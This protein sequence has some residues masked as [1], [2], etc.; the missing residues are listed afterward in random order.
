MKIR[1]IYGDN[2]GMEMLQH[3]AISKMMHRIRRVEVEV[4]EITEELEL[5]RD[6]DFWKALGD[7]RQGRV[8]RYKNIRQLKTEIGV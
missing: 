6:P 4:E 8:T 3:N 5:M 1:I 7:A 2:V